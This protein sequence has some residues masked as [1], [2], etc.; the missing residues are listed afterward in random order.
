[1]EDVHKAY[2]A[3]VDARIAGA[4]TSQ[5]AMAAPLESSN[6]S[7]AA[8]KSRNVASESKEEVPKEAPQQKLGLVHALLSVGALRPAIFILSKFPWMVDAH[9]ELADL[10]LRV[11]HH[12]FARLYETGVDMGIPNA[13]SKEKLASFATPRARYGSTGLAPAPQRKPQLSLVAPTPPVT[14]TT[15][16]VFFFPDW[17]SRVPVCASFDDLEDV[18]EPLMRFI[19]VHISRDP[20]FFTKLARMGKQHIHT[21]VSP[22]LHQQSNVLSRILQCNIDQTTKKQVGLP[23]AQ[24]PIMVFWLKIIRRYFLPALSLIRGNAVCTVDVWNIIKQYE[25]T[26][27]W[28]LYGEWKTS[29]YRSHPE[30]RI[31]FVQ[32]DR[33]AKGIMRRLSLQTVET[34]STAVAKLAQS[35]PCIFF[36]NAVNQVMAYDNLADVVIK[37]LSFIT[38]MGFDALVYVILD[39]FAN[40]NK[41]RVK[42]DGV[43]TSDWLL[44]ACT[45]YGVRQQ[46]FPNMGAGLASFTGMLYRRYSADLSPILKY[47]VHQLHNGQTGDLVVFRELIWKMAGI[48][49]LPSLSEAQIAS[50]AGGPTLRIEAVASETRGARQDVSDPIKKANARLGNALLSSELARPLLIQVAQQRQSCLFQVSDAHLKSL[51]HMSDMVRNVICRASLV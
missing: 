18:A 11:V 38:V 4:K 3:R 1:M 14:S 49:P 21:I 30:L 42:D 50:M 27:R 35:N 48:E 46:C 13:S 45:I 2:L 5:L 22:V 15:E 26:T 7:S 41:Q 16:F 43:N 28:Q 36:A 10:M 6:S 12:S 19:G 44:S 20:M 34:L 40:P 9:T 24:H 33:E 37:S 29:I 8:S 23:D 51:A 25:T 31:R 47:I 32:A 17:A 39:A